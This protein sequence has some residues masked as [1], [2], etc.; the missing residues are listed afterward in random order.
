PGRG[1]VAIV[2]VSGTMAPAIAQTLLGGLPA[3]RV[4]TFGRWRDAAGEIIDSGIAILFPAPASFTGEDVLELQGHAGLIVEALIERVVELGAR[5]AR[6]GEFSERAF[7]NDKIDLAQAEAIADLID[8]GSRGAARAA[9]R[10]LQ[11]EFSARVQAT[12]AALT[13]LRVYV[14]AAI[15]FPEEEIDFLGSLELRER[16]EYVQKLLDDVLTAARRGAQL[17]RGLT[18]VIA[19]RPNAG[20]ST[21]LNALAG[22]DAAIVTPVAGTTRDPLRVQLE[23]HGVPVELIDTAGLR[24]GTRDAIEAEGMRRAREAI[25]R[26]D[27]LLYVVDAAE[28][29]GAHSFDEERDALPAGV[30]VTLVMNKSDLA[31]A[32]AQGLSLSAATGEGMEALRERLARMAGH[33]EAAGGSF[34]A[35]ARHVDALQRAAA[36][37]AAARAQLEAKQGELAAFELRG[38]QASLGEVIGDVTSD[39]LLGHVFRS[40][41]IGK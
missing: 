11:G 27:H 33:T 41:C 13:N 25:A 8:A 32:T 2:R 15:D 19:G 24:D 10:S 5:R 39:E 4:A 9:M 14:E 34:S 31:G 12:R 1:G 18:V 21:L 17:T 30:P 29:P 28:D 22:Y 16:V 26:A 36:Q 23:I 38:A 3:P 40:F 7:I 35:R 20:K 37:L 6:P